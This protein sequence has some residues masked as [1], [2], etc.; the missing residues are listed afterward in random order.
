MPSNQQTQQNF[1]DASLKPKKLIRSDKIPTYADEITE[2]KIN[3]HITR[4]TF[5]VISPDAD[6]LDSNHTIVNESVTVALPTTNFLAAISQMIV[7]LV[8]NEQLLQVISEDYSNISEY[9]KAQLEQ[10][11]S[12]KK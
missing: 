10:L 11:K 12:V 3:S 6:T 1:F 9:A 7:P 8:E 4:L 5:G 2:I